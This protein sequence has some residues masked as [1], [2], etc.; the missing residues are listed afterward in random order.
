MSTVLAPL[1]SPMYE[2]ACE[3][4]NGKDATVPGWIDLMS[5][6]Y[7]SAPS[8]GIPASLLVDSE[9]SA[10]YESIESDCSRKD[11]SEWN[12]SGVMGDPEA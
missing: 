1:P 9:D 5:G 8:G 10:E 4:R 11:S 6:G 7:D 12:C 2:S 3:K